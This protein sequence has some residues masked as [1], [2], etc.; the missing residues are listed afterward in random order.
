[1]IAKFVA[2]R[3]QRAVTAPTRHCF[4]LE[5]CG[6]VDPDRSKQVTRLKYLYWIPM[7]FLTG[8]SW[9]HGHT[10]FHKQPVQ[11]EPTQLIVSGAPAGSILL[12]DGARAGAENS[13]AGKSQLLAVEPGMHTVEVKVRDKIAYRESTYVAPGEKHVVVVL[14]G[15]RGE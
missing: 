14:S 13:T 8:C 10:W 5:L 15:N 7:L 3:R 12:L 4:R 11:P 1:M 9:L 6:I 2:K